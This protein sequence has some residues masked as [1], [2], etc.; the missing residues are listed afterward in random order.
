MGCPW[1]FGWT[2]T[3]F[4]GDNHE[5]ARHCVPVL[6]DMNSAIPGA[7]GNLTDLGTPGGG[8]AKATRDNAEEDDYEAKNRARSI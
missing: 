7:R 2:A 1:C 3:R 6:V 8:R 5:R 4:E